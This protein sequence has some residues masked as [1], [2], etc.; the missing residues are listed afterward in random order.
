MNVFCKIIKQEQATSRSLK[1]PS[2]YDNIALLNIENDAHTLD[3][4]NYDSVFLLHVG[5]N[6]MI[7]C[8]ESLTKVK[9][10][11]FYSFSTL[12]KASYTVKETNEFGLT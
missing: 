9:L 2:Q 11:Y 12:H 10:N 6:T 4:S 3:K 1:I 7:H 5:E 8:L